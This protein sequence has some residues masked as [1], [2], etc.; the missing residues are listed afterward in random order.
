MAFQDKEDRLFDRRTVEQNIKKGLITR[1]D[2][3]EYLEGLDDAEEN[4][5]TMEAEYEEGVLEDDEEEEAEEG[6]E[7]SEEEE[8]DEE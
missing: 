3:N 2:Y 6:E 8:E 1:E 7:A 5:A 4:A